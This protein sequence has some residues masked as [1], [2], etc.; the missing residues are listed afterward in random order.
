MAPTAEPPLKMCV[1]PPLDTVVPMALPPEEMIS[2]PDTLVALATPPFDRICL[3]PLKTIVPMA[4]PPEET[5]SWPADTI[6]AI[7]R[8][9][10]GQ[11]AAADRR[12]DS[13]AAL[14]DHLGAAG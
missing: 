9:E 11:V 1:W 7:V 3:A 8:P 10:V 5:D 13:E 2:S 4:T 6:V 14:P 12:G